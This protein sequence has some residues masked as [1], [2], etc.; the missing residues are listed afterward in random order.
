MRAGSVADSDPGQD[1]GGGGGD[2]QRRHE[3]HRR[4]QGGQ[5]EQPDRPVPGHPGEHHVL[6]L[7]APGEEQRGPAEDDTDP[8]WS[9]VSEWVSDDELDADGVTECAYDD[10]QAVRFTRGFL[11]APERFIRAALDA[12]D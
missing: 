11:D 2:D 8:R 9:G 5:Y 1:R 4:G 6:E 3:E 10:L 12:E 7:G